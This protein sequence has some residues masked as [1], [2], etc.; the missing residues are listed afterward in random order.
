MKT[1]YREIESNYV[2]GVFYRAQFSNGKPSQRSHEEITM[3]EFH[4]FCLPMLMARDYA[5]SR[6][7]IPGD[8]LGILKDTFRHTKKHR[9]Y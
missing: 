2:P 7:A 9:N 4:L 1:E 8:T 5:S 6:E 3:G